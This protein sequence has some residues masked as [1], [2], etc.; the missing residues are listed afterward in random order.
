ML[1]R[2]IPKEIQLQKAKVRNTTFRER[3]TTSFPTSF[4]VM[5][6]PLASQLC[7][8]K[9]GLVRM[10]F[11]RVP[12]PIVDAAPKSFHHS[13][14]SSHGSNHPMEANLLGGLEPWN[15]MTF[16]FIYG[17]SSETHWRSPWFFKRVIAP[18]SRNG[19]SHNWICWEKRGVGI[20][21]IP[22]NH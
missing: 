18:P 6:K 5:V 4:R 8:E 15:F 7:R 17:M 11:Q 12:I 16:Q 14:K 9:E 19:P 13:R 22:K 1:A 20:P 2:R 10:F 21:S 3:R